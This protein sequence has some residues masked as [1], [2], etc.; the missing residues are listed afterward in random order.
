MMV[1]VLQCVLEISE[2]EL[3]SGYYVNLQTNN[4]VK[5][6]KPLIPTAVG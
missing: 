5:G 2:F 4:L 3:Q 6:M 1:N